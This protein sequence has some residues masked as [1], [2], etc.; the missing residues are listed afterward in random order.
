MLILMEINVRSSMFLM[1]CSFS[2]CALFMR[3]LPYSA[4]RSQD[5]W[6]RMSARAQQTS[7]NDNLAIFAMLV[8]AM[9]L[10]LGVL[11]DVKKEFEAFDAI[12]RTMQRVGK[13]SADPANPSGELCL[14]VVISA[15]W[16]ELWG[17]GLGGST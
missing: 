2:C 8:K 6:M 14:H 4:S 1:L 13:A 3:V 15:V 11:E 7:D 12:S 10:H 9:G 16:L 17:L 5:E